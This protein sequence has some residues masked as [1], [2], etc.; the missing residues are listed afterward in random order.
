[1]RRFVLPALFS[2]AA[3]ATLAAAQTP[4]LADSTGPGAA[5]GWPFAVGER[6]TF[7]GKFGWLP[8]GRAEV[9]IDARDTVRGHETYRV[10]FSVNGGPSWFGVHDNYT[11]WFDAKT[12]VSYRYF[13]DI[14]EGRYKRTSTYDIYPDQGIYTRN[15]TDTNVTV[16]APLDDESF[17][18]FIRTVPLSVGL[19]YEWNRYFMADRNPV[20]VDV[21]RKE[22]IEVPAGKFTCYV[23]RP[24]I[25]TTGIF[26]EGGHAEV[27][28]SADDRRLIVQMKSGLSF[29]SL[30]LYLKSYTLGGADTTRAT[31]H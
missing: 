29:G 23:L 21:V 3:C 22:E 17:L 20:I 12:L 7:E 5:N 18:Y 14:R 25:K 16:P 31:G 24:T 19:H 13:Q 30:N 2:L 28:I 10:R 1:M 26:A 9:M 8:V 27:W 6:M 4:A 15:G 11:S